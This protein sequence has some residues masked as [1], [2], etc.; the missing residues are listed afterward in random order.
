MG[1]NATPT[2]SQAAEKE[3]AAID[4]VI[5]EFRPRLNSSYFSTTRQVALR[6]RRFLEKNGLT[7]K[8]M[9]DQ[10]LGQEIVGAADGAESSR[11]LCKNALRSVLEALCK[12]GH[13]ALAFERCVLRAD[14]LSRHADPR[15][16]TGYPEAVTGIYPRWLIPERFMR[17]IEN[18]AEAPTEVRE[19]FKSFAEKLK[20]KLNEASLNC[21]WGQTRDLAKV[22]GIQSLRELSGQAGIAKLQE[23]IESRRYN[24]KT[25]TVTHWRRI[26]KAVLRD[27]SPFRMK[28]ADGEWIIKIP[29]VPRNPVIAEGG[30][31]H[32]NGKRHQVIDGI[33]T[34]NRIKAADLKRLVHYENPRTKKWREAAVAGRAELYREAQEDLLVKFW[35]IEKDRPVELWAHNWGDWK[36]YTAQAEN[37]DSQLFDGDGE[38]LNNFR[39]STVKS[40]P[41]KPFPKWLA[42]RLQEL[43]LLRRAFFAG[44]GDCDEELSQETGILRPGVPLWADPRTGRRASSSVI[45]QMLRNGIVRAGMK[46]GLADY[47]TGYWFRKGVISAEWMQ[48]K[49][50]EYLAKTDG[51]AAKTAH[52]HYIT[53]EMA[54]WVQHERETYWSFLGINR[55][56]LING[57]G[58]GGDGAQSLGQIKQTARKLLEQLKD[59]VPG[60]HEL[61]EGQLERMASSVAF[62]RD[63][64]LSEKEAAKVLLISKSTVRRWAELGLLEK[65]REGGK[66]YFLKS[67]LQSF[68]DTYAF[69]SEVAKTVGTSSSYVRRLCR[70]GRIEGAQR[71]GAKSYLVPRREIRRLMR[72]NHG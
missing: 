53:E 37:L 3:L 52:K 18:N 56:V 29:D 68:L 65:Y 72:R 16:L 5:E 25:S 48:G 17:G 7:L 55:A 1:P 19:E 45:R 47:I 30:S 70:A 35:A 39:E 13:L 54:Q 62:D 14:G 67:Q 58:A 44:K 8:Q 26:L 32:K 69:V 4:Q 60:I 51:H 28:D 24:Q 63:G 11:D 38:L 2:A 50:N 27:Q 49:L 40:R 41:H 42:K 59:Q 10:D 33:V 66:V 21:Y 12:K 57:T 31:F 46:P 23:V 6:L 9:V 61:S 71:V 43:W 36:L 20:G 22:S 15:G 64:R 34:E